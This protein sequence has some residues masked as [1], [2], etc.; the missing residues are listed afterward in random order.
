MAEFGTKMADL[1][2]RL[3]TKFGAVATWTHYVDRDRGNPQTHTVLMAA[4]RLVELSDG[5]LNEDNMA[6]ATVAAKGLTFVPTIGDE[7]RYL[8]RDLVVRAV[9]VVNANGIVA[10]YRVKVAG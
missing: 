6:E 7:V 8:G 9:D 1:A 2:V 10:A 4:P 5:D 3:V